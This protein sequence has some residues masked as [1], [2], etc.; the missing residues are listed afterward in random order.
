VD[1]AQSRDDVW[2]LVAPFFCEFR[3]HKHFV[4]CSH[5]CATCPPQD[6][7]AALKSLRVPLDPTRQARQFLA[8]RLLV[9]QRLEC[10][11]QPMVDNVVR[12]AQTFPRK[13]S[14]R[15][16]LR[17]PLYRRRI[18]AP[19][20]SSHIEYASVVYTCSQETAI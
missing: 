7:C 17:K 20:I 12:C 8:T 3:T 2:H 6:D 10:V 11:Y 19:Y 14:G 4:C 16:W 18:P 5:G 15:S 13:L 1:D 9:L